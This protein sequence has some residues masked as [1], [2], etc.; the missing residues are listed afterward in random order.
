M[1]LFRRRFLHLLAGAAAL[2]TVSRTAR[3]QAYPTRPI[4]LVIPYPPGGVVD[5]IGRPWANSMKSLLGTVV[6]ENIG[7][8]G[9][10]MG[11]A[12]VSRARPDGYTILLANSSI[13]VIN[14]LAGSHVSYDPIGSFDAVSI[15]GHVAQAIAINPTLPVRTLKELADYATRNPGT[16]SYGTPGV[17]TLNHLTGERFKLL[18]GSPDIVHVPY[19]GAGPA[20]AD[21]IGGQIP[22]AVPAVNGQLLAFHQAGKLTILAVTSPERL[23]S[24]PDLSTV[25]E[26]GMPELTAQATT[27]LFVPKGTPRVI[28]DGISSA[29]GKALAEPELRQIY[30]GS[31][32]EPSSDASPEAATQ[33][34]QNEIARWKP[35]VKQIELKL[36]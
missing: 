20:I 28:I 2:A 36:D 17:G 23:Q 18:I 34:L 3:A 14:P 16:L 33:L 24:A 10:E 31:G 21:L 4:R 6:V 27:W 13:M 25:S 35:V 8:G 26:A 1:K 29:T 22:M 30:L 9:G 11:A 15:V 7:G 19:R 5:A 32:I 12:T